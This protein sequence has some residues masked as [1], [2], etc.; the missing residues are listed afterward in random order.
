MILTDITATKERERELAD[1]TELLQRTLENMG[2]G[3]DVYDK[4]MRLVAWNRRLLELLELPSQLTRVGTAFE[5]MMRFLAERG[6][7]G[8]VDVEEIV[9]KRVEQARGNQP[10]SFAG[11]LSSG[12]YLEVR[13][14]PMPGGGFVTMVSDVTERKHAEEALEESRQMLRV[15]IDQ[16]PA[17]ISVKDRDLRYILVNKAQADA[18]GE[19]AAGDGQEIRRLLQPQIHGRH[20]ARLY[21]R[22]R[23]ARPPLAGRRVHPVP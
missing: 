1:K 2:E 13:R 5:T 12:R 17:R 23:R 20:L 22:C 14:N 15:V 10:Y 4:D 11:W 16:V 8:Q 7:F 19:P 18:L 9:Q 3:I 21:G 6:D